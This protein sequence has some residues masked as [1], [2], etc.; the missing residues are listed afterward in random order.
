MLT[1][2]TLVTIAALLL[3]VALYESARKARAKHRYN[4]RLYWLDQAQRSAG[5]EA[6]KNARWY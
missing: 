3:L 1:T 2:I 6:N 4:P 5:L